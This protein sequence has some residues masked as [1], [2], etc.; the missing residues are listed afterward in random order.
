MARIPGASGS[1]HEPPS[2]AIGGRGGFIE[3]TCECGLVF[4][5]GYRA[6][7]CPECQ[8]AT[9]RVAKQLNRKPRK[10]AAYYHLVVKVDQ[11]KLETHRLRSVSSRR[12]V[13]DWL[14]EYKVSRGCLD[15]GWAEHYAGLELDHTCGKTEEIVKARSSIKRLQAE[16]EHGCCVVR[17]STHHGVKS[18]AEKNRHSDPTGYCHDGDG[19]AILPRTHP[20][21]RR[22]L[23]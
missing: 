22:D 2:C 12:I 10:G 23:P 16:I 1:R 15:C 17:C 7:R 21:Q 18:W 14:H 9:N 5:G 11:Q 4:I 20:N 6:L 19:C 8:A 13:N 3:K